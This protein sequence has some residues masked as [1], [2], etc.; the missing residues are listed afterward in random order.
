MAVQDRMHLADGRTVDLG[1]ALPKP[2][3]NLGCAPARILPLDLDDRLLDDHRQ[4]FRVAMGPPAA[5]P[6][7]LD[8]DLPVP[9]I[10]LVAGFAGSPNS[11][12][13]ATIVSPSSKRAT[14]RSRSPSRD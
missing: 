14:N 2:L 12:H 5:I 6:Q 3:P 9:L 11:S 10:N 8:A 7:P 13:N 4:L 1:P